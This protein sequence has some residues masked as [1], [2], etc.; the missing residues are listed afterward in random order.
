MKRFLTMLGAALMLPVSGWAQQPSPIA[1]DDQT[2][3]VQGNNAFAVEL[4]GQ[5]RSQSGNL[6]FS[7]ESISTALAMT[8]AGARGDTAAEMAK[9]LHLTLPQEKLHATMAALLRDLNAAHDGYQLKVANA[10][11][12]QQGYTFLDDFLKLTRNNYGD[13]LHQVD[14]KNAS[15]SARQTINDWV[16]Q[17]T[18]NKIKDLIQPGVLTRNTRMVLTNAVY[19]K[20]DWLTQFDKKLTQEENFHVTR[21]QN[22]RVPLM[23]CEDNFNYL[24]GGTFQA[25]EI[26]YKGKELSMIVF[27]PSQ[28][29][30]LTAFE[31]S[32]TAANMQQWLGQLQPAS[33]VQL[34]MPTFKVTAQ[35]Q[36]NEV[37]DRMGMRQA[38]DSRVA[39]F[40][41]MTGKRELFISAVVHKAFVDVN[42]EGT[43][44]A[45]ATVLMEQRPDIAIREL[46]PPVFRADHPFFFVIRENRFGSILFI[47]RV[48]DPSR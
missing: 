17:Q 36:L 20:G 25:L 13:E 26:P 46:P 48:A 8:Y 41:A 42:E 9:T 32:L 12:A 14:F 45:A 24:D 15:E 43:E 11:W 21:T 31:Q 40:S 35:F 33:E 16:E 28:V 5:L 6:F 30:G 39:D 4:Y 47:G 19:F 29:D 7:P 3:V 38:F 34:S 23:H 2:A 18:A 44:A 1:P 10:L 37:L 27:L 22:V